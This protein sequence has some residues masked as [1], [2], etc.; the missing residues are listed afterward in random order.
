ML[1]HY[2]IASNVEQMGQ[3]FMF[4]RSDRLLGVLPFFHS[5]GFTVTLWLPAALG[6]RR[7]LSSESA[8]PDRRSAK[9][10]AITASRS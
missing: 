8:R 1:T 6:R 3:T 5:F 10:C 9:S 7:R 4:D 2:N